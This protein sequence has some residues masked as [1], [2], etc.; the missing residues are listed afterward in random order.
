MKEN[1]SKKR[2]LKKMVLA[3]G[4]MV[5]GVGLAA[6]FSSFTESAMDEPIYHDEKVVGC[7]QVETIPISVTTYSNYSGS[8]EGSIATSGGAVTG[9]TL[10]AGG[11]GTTYSSVTAMAS[12]LSYDAT[13]A[14]DCKTTF[15]AFCDLFA[16]A[17]EA[18]S[19]PDKLLY[20]NQLYDIP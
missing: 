11:A 9:L 2:H 6:V 18:G 14:V 12:V 4:A 10:G 19:S 15:L 16:C 1:P 5:A 13:T 8:G 3:T 17:R 20:N 7:T